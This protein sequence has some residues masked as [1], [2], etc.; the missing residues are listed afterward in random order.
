MKLSQGGKQV[1]VR[2]DDGREQELVAHPSTVERFL[3]KPGAPVQTLTSNSVGVV[4]DARLV[5]QKIFYNVSFPGN[6]KKALSE[7]GLRPAVLTDPLERLRA[8]QVANPRKFA[9]RS[10]AARYAFANRYDEFASLENSRIEAK[11]HQISV[12]HR[13]ISAYPHRFLLCDEV[14]LGKTV[15][16]GMV[17][18]ELRAR[19]V[20]KRVLIL[21][22]ANLRLQWQSE[23]KNKFNETFSVYDRDS[24]K[25]LKQSSDQN[26]WT[27]NDSIITS[28]GY[29]THTDE[30]M[31][32]IASVDW[33]VVIIDEAHHA[34][35][36]HSGSSSRK[37][38]LYRLAEHL[39]DFKEGG[40][41]SLLLL[42]AT[43]MQ[44]DPKE[45][46]SLV[47][48]LDPALFPT[49]EAFEE[50]RRLLPELNR[51]VRAVENYADVT[52]VAKI[53]ADGEG[54]TTVSKAAVLDDLRRRVGV[55]LA[56]GLSQGHGISASGRD[57][58]ALNGAL[59]SEAG[60]E[61]IVEALRWK[62]RLSEVLIRNRKTTVGGFQPRQAFSW[63]VEH[64]PQERDAYAAVERYV[65][66]G[67]ER[68][69]TTQ[70]NALGFVMVIFQKLMAS[71]SRAL[72]TSLHRRR[73]RLTAK[74][75]L[76]RDLLE[77]IDAEDEEAAA[78]LVE[79]ASGAT[80]EFVHP[81][82]L[83]HL[84]ELVSS[85]EQI[86]MDSKARVLL[87]RMKALLVEDSQA[88]VLIFTQFRETQEMLAEM[89]R[90]HW[91]VYLFH[92]QLGAHAKDRSMDGFRKDSG[93]CFMISTE[94]G[95]EGRNLQFCHLL[96]N[97]DLPWNPMRVEQRIGRVDRIG[98]KNVVTVFNVS[99]KGT[100]EERVLD[101]LERRIG[102]FK[103]TVGGLDPI[104]GE[105]ETDLRE[106]FKL[107]QAQ[108]ERALKKLERSLE[109][110]VKAARKAE[111]QL[112]DFIM[113][114]RSFQ[115]EIARQ[116]M[117]REGQIDHGAVRRFVQTLLGDRRTKIRAR[118]DGIYELVFQEPLLS[119][120]PELIE[121]GGAVRPACFE[122]GVA[123]EAES[124]QFFTFGHPIVDAL[125]ENVLDGAYKGMATLRHVRKSGLPPTVGYQFTYVLEVD[126]IEPRK[127]V[128]SVFVGEDGGVD[129]ELGRQLLELQATF[130]DESGD[131]EEGLRDLGA[132]DAAH[133]AAEFAAAVALE[134]LNSRLIERNRDNLRREREKLVGYFDYREV[135]AQDKVDHARSVVGRLQASDDPSLQKILP[136]W[137]TNLARAIAVQEGL[138]EERARRL[139]ELDRR[140]MPVA[141]HSLLGVARVVIHPTETAHL[142]PSTEEVSVER[143]QNT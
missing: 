114:A 129:E 18:K 25:F 14:G 23:L 32:E 133:E 137:K 31:E 102:L 80:G 54:P 19:G 44:L 126:G 63:P 34:R 86:E 12:A 113:D 47:E 130:N 29:A 26:V 106:I 6:V 69:R 37:N 27:R 87:E 122:P 118:D 1:R 124:V 17:L 84:D 20:A 50:Q 4:V 140:S 9:L 36:Y 30:R 119:D 43:P 123:R 56:D 103:Q 16:A 71:S 55:A 72:R 40:R 67:Y 52:A 78:P 2:F 60:R 90:E 105:V 15:E 28:D 21:V 35:V 121:D 66:E 45:L 41:R 128:F 111:S 143:M 62:H 38:R 68:A 59:E 127:E 33:D 53:L 136:V 142:E 125:V 42:T 93:P 51:L 131:V 70:N 82:E 110:R 139:A 76:G 11:P 99:V 61:R 39:A 10:T 46:Y 101:V 95:G 81:E 89:L 65:R 112:A 88:K 5:D 138:G 100:V 117:D 75:V 49:V 48:L 98:Q 24:V 91:P 77:L 132:L 7:T 109:Q 108:R 104:L 96:V 116:I 58:V 3:F 94:A 73:E 135:A 97:Y 134:K 74:T 13:V 79:M 141:A 83:A 64:T 115:P 57:A 92:G 22:P 107:A 8:R 85:L 120:L